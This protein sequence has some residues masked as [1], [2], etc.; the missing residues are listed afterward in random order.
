MSDM[1][2]DDITMSEYMEELDVEWPC[3]ENGP[4]ERRPSWFWLRE[5]TS[6][7]AENGMDVQGITWDSFNVTRQR[8]R[9]L[10][11]IDYKNYENIQ[12]SHDEIKK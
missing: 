1:L 5:V 10:R 4:S 9:E 3:S 2:D 6:Q 8:Y 12:R 11:L 7:D